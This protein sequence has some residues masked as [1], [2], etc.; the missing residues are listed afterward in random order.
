[1]E[2]SQSLRGT[3]TWLPPNFLPLPASLGIVGSPR[4]RTLGIM[5][6]EI[7]LPLG[8]QRSRG[9]KLEAK[10]SKKFMR[11]HLNKQVRWVMCTCQPSYIRTVV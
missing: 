9:S 4:L 5:A 2:R 3:G 10:L 1:M 7:T 11:P 8:R 6:L